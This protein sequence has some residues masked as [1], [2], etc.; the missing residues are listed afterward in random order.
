MGGYSFLRGLL[1]AVPGAGIQ[2]ARDAGHCV[3]R[4]QPYAGIRDAGGAAH[5]RAGIEAQIPR[6]GRDVRCGSR[7]R[8]SAGAVEPGNG[9]E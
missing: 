5:S 3:V 9:G 4:D 8:V 2:A 6:P 7:R 1:G